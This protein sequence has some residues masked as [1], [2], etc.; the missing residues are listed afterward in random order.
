M[1]IKIIILLLPVAAMVAF[2]LFMVA[3]RRHI[4]NKLRLAV[5][6]AV[7]GMAASFGV[8]RLTLALAGKA[9]VCAPAAGS[10]TGL[11]SGAGLGV[12]VSLASGALYYAARRPA[13]TAQSA[14]NMAVSGIANVSSALIEETSFR[15]G[16]VHF[17]AAFW[18]APAG[19]LG[20][21]APFG[22]LHLLG[23]LWGTPVDLMHVLG[24]AMAGLLLS[25]VYLRW[26]LLPA[27][28]VHW[29]WN[30]LCAFWVPLFG[31]GETGAVNFEGAPTTVFSLT[32][33]SVLVLFLGK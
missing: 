5:S 23:R 16:V 7:T 32:G 26:G 1:L 28:G 20:G 22:L 8:Y 27:I 25:A 17:A 13:L 31:L 2:V 30:S 18:G 6:L 21:S 11:F 3:L 14:K 19:L 12:L 4:R 29:A 9:G 10:L 33:A 24:T 15:G